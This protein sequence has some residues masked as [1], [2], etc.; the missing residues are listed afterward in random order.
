MTAISLFGLSFASQAVELAT[1]EFNNDGSGQDF[2]ATTADAGVTAGDVADNSASGGFAAFTNSSLITLFTSGGAGL[3]GGTGASPSP[4]DEDAYYTVTLSA[5]NVGE[6]LDIDTIDFD[7]LRASNGGRTW[8]IRSD[9]D[10][11]AVD[12]ATGTIPTGG[13]API[14]QIVLGAEHEG[15]TSVEFRI[16]LYGRQSTS[17]GSSSTQL[18]NVTFEGS[19]GVAS[20]DTDADGLDD[21][22]EDEHFGNNDGTAT[23]TELAFQDGTGD[24]FP[25]VD[26]DG[27]T[28][29]EEENAGT[30]PNVFDSDTDGLGDGAE[31]NTH[32]TNP[33]LIDTDDDGLEDGLEVNTSPTDPLNPD[34]DDDGLEDGEEDADMSGS[35]N[36]SET[37]PTN[38]DSDADGVCDGDEVDFD[39]PSDPLVQDDTDGDGIP[40]VIEDTN[41]NC[42]FDAGETDPL[43]TDTDGDNL[44]DGAEDINFDGI[45]GPTETDPRLADTDMDGLNDDVDGDPLNPDQDMDGVVDGDDE[46][47]NDPTN[48]TDGD[49]ISNIN[50]TEGKDGSGTLHAFGPTNPNLIDTDGDGIDDDYEIAGQAQGGTSHGFGPT[51]PNLADSDVDDFDDADELLYGGDPNTF[52][53][54]LP[55]AVLGYTEIGG[56]WLT[57]GTNDIDG[58]GGLGSDGFFFLGEFMDPGANG[59]DFDVA[60][61]ASLPSYVSSVDAGVDAINV[62]YG[63]GFGEIDDPNALDGSDESAGMVIAV[64]GATGAVTEL[65]TFEVAGLV[66]GQTVRVGVLGGTSPATDGRWDPVDLILEGPDGYLAAGLDLELDPGG[67]NAGW[68][69]FDIDTDGVYYVSGAQRLDSQGSSVGG[70]TFDSIGGSS[71][72]ELGIANAAN[73]TDLEFTWE[74]TAGKLY[75]LRRNTDL[76]TDPSTWPIWQADIPADISGTNLEAFTRPVD[77]K[78]FFV[79]EEKSAPVVVE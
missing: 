43:N 69:F 10:S 46:F 72:V 64:G 3:A 6:A 60:N 48:D 36:G 7:A 56:D 58:S 68:L 18:D 67:L 32:G 15:L 62:S 45:V 17:N 42:V 24:G 25:V 74:S 26:G 38:P 66:D 70:L 16:Y 77:S 71:F 33:T 63:S 55:H 65:M 11:F 22:W 54:S 76:D 40:N 31:I 44:L 53:E 5:A 39:P 21:L 28:N 78:S 52:E 41:V 12:L 29:E 19:V 1:Y 75:D 14:P 59:Q 8:S 73:G 27:L 50:E 51:N 13:F 79:L 49:T 47:P 34:S 2:S 57:M 20:D 35:Q 4:F 30:D 37:D 9:V 23:P 61:V